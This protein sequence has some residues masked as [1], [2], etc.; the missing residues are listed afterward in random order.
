M[1]LTIHS[2]NK[3]IGG[4]CVEIASGDTRII[5]DVG[6][7]L[8]DKDGNQIDSQKLEK[9][10]GQELLKEK[11]LADVKG[12]YEW[13]KTNK[14]VD[15]VLITHP[16]ADHFGYLKF[17]NPDIPV[18]VGA[19]AKKLIELN[20]KVFGK[21]S[22]EIKNAVSVVHEQEF[23][24]GNIKIKPFAMDHSAFDSYAYEIKANGKTLIY[25]CDFRAHG[26]KW[27]LFPLFLRKV[28]KNPDALVMEG[29]V[30]GSN[31]REHDCK[32]EDE[33]EEQIVKVARNTKDVVFVNTS[34]QNID[35]QVSLYRAAIRS[36]RTFVV[37]IYTAK[38]LDTVWKKESKLI[39]VLNRNYKIKIFYP[40]YLTQKLVEAF[41]QNSTVYYFQSKMIK[42][43]ELVKTKKYIM[44]VHASMI[45][46][47]P[48]RIFKKNEFFC[49]DSTFIY[50]QWHGYLERDN[51]QLL[52][53]FFD[54][55]GAKFEEIHT[56]GHADEKTLEKTVKTIQP[57]RVFPIHTIHPELYE[58]FGCKVVEELKDGEPFEI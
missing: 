50:S 16:H 5:I 22:F 23:N 32:T 36:G 29:T 54:K 51:R 21:E 41:N 20:K 37:D 3:V 30:M 13:D 24:I 25:C 8:M 15:A 45:K 33:L 42:P 43:D 31:S 53:K 28:T 11:K 44:L 14:K 9:C 48:S 7:P 35:R 52:K 10:S 49:K 47:F 38:V 56:G 46:D 57:K 27:K 6:I 1:N 55:Q 12:L 18:Y 17:V 2:G 40:I 26:R 39:P 34:A 4:I 19:D 58:K